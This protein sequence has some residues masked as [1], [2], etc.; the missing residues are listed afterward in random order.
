LTIFE[1]VSKENL[2]IRPKLEGQTGDGEWVELT[3]PQ[4]ERVRRLRCNR[5][6]LYTPSIDPINNPNEHKVYAC[7]SVIVFH[8]P[9]IGYSNYRA[10]IAFLNMQE[11]YSHGIINGDIFTQVRDERKKHIKIF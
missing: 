5:G 10:T 6:A 4:E 7:N 9:F 1:D 11:L 2:K 8:Q 3:V